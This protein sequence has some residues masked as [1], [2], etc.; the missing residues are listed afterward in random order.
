MCLQLRKRKVDVCCLYK[1]QGREAKE[2]NLLV[3]R[4]EDITCGGLEIMME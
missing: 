1:K 4:V 2:L 3:S